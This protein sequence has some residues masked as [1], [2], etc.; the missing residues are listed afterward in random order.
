MAK[1]KF[2]A[3]QTAANKRVRHELAILKRKGIIAKD[4]DVRNATST[5]SVRKLI[6]R[7]KD[8]L[9]GKAGT[10]KVTGKQGK[11]LSDKGYRIVGKKREKRAVV[12]SSQYVR[13]GQVYERPTRSRKGYKIEQHQLTVED[14]EA[15]IRDAFSKGKPGDNFGFE[16]GGEGGRGGHSVDIF[17]SPE[18]MIEQLLA[19]EERGFKVQHL[20][21]YRST[22]ARVIERREKV[23]G[24][25]EYRAARRKQVAGRKR[26]I[27]TARGH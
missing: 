10:F 17:H 7:N 4:Y 25:R 11:A 9:T 15:T 13:K 22:L 16:V 8:V 18:S 14:Y 20:T 27:R 19:Y 1:R 3:T 26:G 6:S 24:S 21:V 23:I 12:P 5:G 2:T